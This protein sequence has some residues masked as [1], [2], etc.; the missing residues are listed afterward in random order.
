M[1]RIKR[2][3][4]FYFDENINI[5]HMKKTGTLRIIDGD[6]FSINGRETAIEMIRSICI[7]S[8]LP[9]KSLLS[10]FGYNCLIMAKEILNEIEH[11]SPDLLKIEGCTSKVVRIS[12]GY[13][14]LN[15]LSFVIN[16]AKIILWR[17]NTSEITSHQ[18][19]EALSFVKG[20]YCIEPVIEYSSP[21][22]FLRIPAYAHSLIGNEEDS[23]F[24]RKLSYY[25]GQVVYKAYN[26]GVLS[27]SP[28]IYT[29][30]NLIKLVDI[31]GLGDYSFTQ[32][33]RTIY[34]FWDAPGWTHHFNYK[35][36]RFNASVVLRSDVI[37]ID[38]IFGYLNPGFNDILRKSTL[39]L[40]LFSPEDNLEMN[41]CI[42]DLYHK[43]SYLARINHKHCSK[44]FDGRIEVSMDTNYDGEN[45]EAASKKE[46]YH[47]HLFSAEFIKDY[48]TD[49]GVYFLGPTDYVSD[50]EQFYT[51]FNY[52][53]GFNDRCMMVIDVNISFLYNGPIEL[54]ES[55]SNRRLYHAS[56][57]R[58]YFFVS[59]DVLR[60]SDFGELPDDFKFMVQMLRCVCRCLAFR[61][62]VH[63][64]GE[65]ANRLD[66]FPVP[67]LFDSDDYVNVS[68]EED[69]DGYC[70][71]IS[72]FNYYKLSR[73]AFV[74]FGSCIVLFHRDVKVLKRNMRYRSIRIDFDLKNKQLKDRRWHDPVEQTSLPLA[75][76]LSPQFLEVLG[77]DKMKRLC[78]VIKDFPFLYEV[79]EKSKKYGTVRRYFH[80]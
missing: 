69:Y 13:V 78:R 35:S 16:Y 36:S 5:E 34:P 61:Y 41:C 10:M 32:S 15:D 23:K 42:G 6:V 24:Y 21:S 38:W 19:F 44:S 47:P 46:F 18:F 30:S 50:R 29:N 1:S 65:L 53:K 63:T 55:Y 4:D 51:C 27:H 79:M 8:G 28:G 76:L 73:A 59:K 9:S 54:G 14:L 7:E 80:G 12:Q 67:K 70:N 75:L 43:Y 62:I 11:L 48:H 17:M 2:I 56:S 31:K 57:T 37:S 74:P 45:V 26:G 40:S 66:L 58:F 71:K 68:K 22:I 20:Y 39:R 25:S 49:V 77:S 3:E 72:H 52:F 33:F 64:I 60:Y